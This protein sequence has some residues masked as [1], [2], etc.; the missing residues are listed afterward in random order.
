MFL[1]DALTFSADGKT[2]V[3]CDE[4]YEGKVVVP[5]SMSELGLSPSST[6]ARILS[7]IIPNKV[8]TIGKDAFRNCDKITS[9]VLPDSITLIEENAFWGCSSLRSINIPN[10]VQ[11]IDS[12][13]FD[14]CSKLESIDIPSSVKEIGMYAFSDCSGIRRINVDRD[15]GNYRSEDG[16]LYSKDKSILYKVPPCF[17]KFTI[18]SSVSRLDYNAFSDGCKL[19]TMVIPANVV[20]IESGGVFDDCK[21]IKGFV[22]DKS[23]PVYRDINGALCSKDGKDLI[24]VPEGFETFK[25]PDCILTIKEEAFWGCEKLTEI[26]ISKNV[27]KIE[28]EV[29]AETNGN[30]RFVVAE[31]NPCFC[32]KNGAICS[33]DGKTLLHVPIGLETFTVPDGIVYINADS[34]DSQSNAFE[35]NEKLTS[36]TIPSSVIQIGEYTFM[37]CEKLVE[38]HMKHQTPLEA[39]DEKSDLDVA[40]VTLFVPRGSEGAYRAHPFYSQ[41]AKIVGE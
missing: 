7:V 13:A 30:R 27:M 38:L 9:I 25:M 1:K 32:E 12:F 21:D 2:L 31:D 22:V 23:N 35:S 19:T 10:K 20:D 15:N 6:L 41:F 33:K 36:V 26:E 37:D 14:D 11:K 34:N 4:S 16:V 8:T 40:K 3:K 28:T 5:S 39:F 18:P 29:F 24:R 17:E